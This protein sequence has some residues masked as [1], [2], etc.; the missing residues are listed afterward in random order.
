MADETP[1]PEKSAADK[2]EEDIKKYGIAYA[3]MGD[4]FKGRGITLATRAVS[5]A[6]AGFAVFV[7]LYAIWSS[8]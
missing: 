4:A 5:W 1:P 7:V 2:M 6:L 3:I 8:L